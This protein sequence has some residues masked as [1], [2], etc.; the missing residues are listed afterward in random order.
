VHWI[1]GAYHR[2]GRERSLGKMTPVEYEGAHEVI[3]RELL[4]A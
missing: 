2:R 3:D 1:E 4:V